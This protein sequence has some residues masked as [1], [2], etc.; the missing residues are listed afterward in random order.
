LKARWSY[1]IAILVFFAFAGTFVWHRFFGLP[2][3]LALK[4]FG[5]EMVVARH[6]RYF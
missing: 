3:P 5:G 1:R 4:A 2:T 6:S